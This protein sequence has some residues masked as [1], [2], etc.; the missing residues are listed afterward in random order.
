MVGISYIRYTQDGNA[1]VIKREIPEQQL[2]NPDYN[3]L[4]QWFHCDTI[5]RNNGKLYFCNKIED[6]EIIEK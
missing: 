3:L 4:K 1:F 5:I 2:K 6:A